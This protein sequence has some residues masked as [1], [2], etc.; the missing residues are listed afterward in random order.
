MKLKD[1]FN[2]TERRR[3]FSLR[4][5]SGIGAVSAVIGII[6]FSSLPLETV[7]ATETAITVNYKYA[8]T[9]E[10]TE[11]E[12][13]LIVNELPKNLV[14]GSDLFVIYRKYTA[15]NTLPNTGS[16]VLPLASIIGT[17]LLLVA[18][19][20]KKTGK[21]D[22]KIVKS[23]LSISLVGGALT[24]TTVS[25]LTVATLLNYNHTE[26]ITAGATFPDGKVK[27]SGYQFVGYI[28]GN[29]VVTNPTTPATLFP[30][31]E[32][33]I[34]DTIV[35][36]DELKK[37]TI[38]DSRSKATVAPIKPL[39]Q[40]PSQGNKMQD[41]IIPTDNPEK[42]NI[43]AD[44]R[45]K[46]EPIKPI[47]QL[48]EDEPVKPVDPK[49]ID[50]IIKVDDSG[51]TLEDV[52][53]YTKISTSQPVKTRE[54][55]DGQLVIIRTV[56]EVYKK[57]TVSEENKTT[58]LLKETNVVIPSTLVEILSE[59]VVED[60]TPV[61]TTPTATSTPD[62]PTVE[63]NE[64]IENTGTAS[65]TGSSVGEDKKEEITSPVEASSSSLET[66]AE[67][68]IVKAKKVIRTMRTTEDI[69]FEV[70]IKKDSSLAEGETK[71]ETEGKLGKKVSI[72]KI[73]LVDN[74]ET[75]K[76]TI[77]ETIEEPQNKVLMIGT[78]KT[79]TQP[80]TSEVVSSASSAATLA[81][82]SKS[83][84]QKTPLPGYYS[85][86]ITESENKTVVTDREKVRELVKERTP[87]LNLIAPD[88][89][90]L[91]QMKITEILDNNLFEGQRRL[92]DIQASYVTVQLKRKKEE[93]GKE[94][95]TERVLKEDIP[96]L[97]ATQRVGTKRL[98]KDLDVTAFRTLGGI[99]LEW[100][101]N[102]GLVYSIQ[103]GSSENQLTTVTSKQE[104]P[105]FTEED[106]TE[107][108]LYYKVTARL[109]DKVV[110]ESQIIKLEKKLDTDK[111]GLNDEE[112]DKYST[113]KFVA[114]SDKDGLTDFQEVHIYKTNP[115]K[116]DTDGDRLRDYDEIAWK[117]NPL[118]PDTD[119]NGITDDLEDLDKDG[120]NNYDESIFKSNALQKDT[121]FDGLDDKA[122]RDLGTNPNE[123]DS[124]GDG[125][126]D[127]LESELGL[128]PL[129][130]DSKGDGIND[131]D[132]KFSKTIKSDK[133]NVD[134]NIVPTI[135]TELPANKLN[136]FYL[137][138]IDDDHP[139]LNKNLP[140]YLGSA[141]EFK[142]G[143][144]I[145]SADVTF[146]INPTL[147]TP[148]SRPVLLYF[149]KEKWE[150]EVVKEQH[151]EGNKLVAKLEHFSPYT[152]VDAKKKFNFDGVVTKNKQEEIKKEYDQYLHELSK[153]LFKQYTKDKEL[154]DGDLSIFANLA[155]KSKFLV[156]KEQLEKMEKNIQTYSGSN[157]DEELKLIPIEISSIYN[158]IVYSELKS[159]INKLVFKNGEDSK[160]IIE[161]EL[162]KLIKDPFS[163]NQFKKVIAELDNIIKQTNSFEDYVASHDHIEITYSYLDTTNR[164]QELQKYYVYKEITSE[165]SSGFDASTWI[166]NENIVISYRGSDDGKDWGNH[167]SYFVN[168]NKLSLRDGL[169]SGIAVGASIGALG[170]PVGLALGGIVGGLIGAGAGGLLGNFYEKKNNTSSP[171]IHLQDQQAVHY[172]LAII[173]KYQNRQYYI[174]GH[175]LGGRLALVANDSAKLLNLTPKTRTFN[176]LGTAKNIYK[177]SYEG[178]IRNYVNIG[179]FL[180][181][182][183]Y[184]PR[185]KTFE[186][187]FGG[188]NPVNAHMMDHMIR[189]YS[190]Y[191]TGADTSEE[192]I[193][194]RLIKRFIFTSGAGGWFTVM[195][196][197]KDGDIKGNYNAPVSG[198]T[199][200]DHP[201]GQVFVSDFTG[202]FTD[203]IKVNDYEY[204]MTLTNLDYPKSGTTKIVNGV[205][206][207]TTE[208]YGI[209]DKKSPGKEFI[210]YLPGRPVQD[211]PEAVGNWIYDFK[212]RM[213]EKLTS[214]VI[215]NKDKGWAFEESDQMIKKVSPEMQYAEILVKYKKLSV[216]GYD[217]LHSVINGAEGLERMVMNFIADG[218]RYNRKVQYSFYDINNDKQEE[219]IIG[220]SS[221]FI[222]SIYTLKNN[223]PVFVK[224]AGM[225]SVGAM[226]LSLSIYQDG[227]IRFIS[228]YGTNPNWEASSYQ[229][230]DG[231]VVEKEKANFIFGQGTDIAKLLNI[232]SDIVNLEKVTWHDLRNFN[233]GEDYKSTT[234]STSILADVS[235]I[236]KGDTSSLEGTWTNSKGATITIKEGKL[237]TGRF[238]QVPFEI[239]TFTRQKEFPLL[240]LNTGDNNPLGNL[241]FVLIPARDSVDAANDT[242]DRTKDR[243]VLGSTVAQTSD[244]SSD[245][246]FYR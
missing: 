94:D 152:I 80:T 187:R 88:G 86:E 19:T 196:V 64:K 157:R 126:S 62:K 219:L 146:D 139:V 166:N 74:V 76:E 175:S 174:T 92:S 99:Y 150:F 89:E 237:S 112:E 84:T 20:I 132:R 209:A 236:M 45:D 216:E 85:V 39:I 191:E 125:V 180:S 12:K 44:S 130:K 75:V 168:K 77:S 65:L 229:I 141:Y 115:L 78:K 161:D 95:E 68:T 23:I 2:A 4:K 147:L 197:S 8:T 51:N 31:Q 184:G 144:P 162:L 202:K 116:V 228:G 183:G 192:K 110:Q 239:K 43:H 32:N 48:K 63:K 54:V 165:L 37:D 160:S 230:K 25:A 153:D 155:Y 149:N 117:L 235:A 224:G 121:D 164:K 200:P 105:V 50:K 159:V 124:D 101:A 53:G 193:F 15:N 14:D 158:K 240:E 234:A 133:G 246:Y 214:A 83:T 142:A 169:F 93:N 171:D 79:A 107:Q 207:E 13:K 73:T 69:P 201:N 72:Q 81:S 185:E 131:G 103:K 16:N 35:P 82:D 227:T 242:S 223:K 22:K 46:V 206:I 156:F 1:K 98:P 221:G 203:L 182:L 96:L 49:V 195:S 145:S 114:D 113:N 29:D 58:D 243:L 30:S 67:P 134:P 204:K 173:D 34:Q 109:G 111:D 26:T 128:N 199:G 41:T 10:L 18:F 56:T 170:G 40:P 24:V 127:R 225:P 21:A 186:G 129:K 60:G 33:K 6:G 3:K 163:T 90:K 181:L 11:T 100:K 42:D 106:T 178:D 28:D 215:F 97:T 245:S 213:P 232:T 154:F 138:K 52:T 119:D 218:S 222:S 238:E 212:N 179:E 102:E 120:L 217:A 61:T 143:L 27:I 87:L 57:D 172:F 70:V 135:T 136:S 188:W 9:D 190:S 167:L 220:E 108:P 91:V 71:V 205:K 137:Y 151:M 231:N 38:D 17:G 241:A 176:P 122:E 140:G 211:L 198:Y 233:Q 59:E 244:I 226:R 177:N 194:E 55:Q 189:D 5:V 210:L 208:P 36:T 47:T 123:L 104:L 7:S 118:K 66:I 148:D